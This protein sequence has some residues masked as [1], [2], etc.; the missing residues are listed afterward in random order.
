MQD[1]VTIQEK[2]GLW[3]RTNK[4]AILVELAVVFVPLY[5]CMLINDRLGS[6]VVSLG[7]STVL[8]GG[9]LL[10]IG[11]ALCLAALWVVSRMRGASWS[12]FGVTRPKSWVRT[13]LM[14]LAVLLVFIVGMVLFGALL[15]AVTDIES[16][17]LSRFAN[18][19]GNL[20]NLIINL[21]VNAWFTAGFLEE[22]LWRGYLM[23]RI[24]DLFEQKSKFAWV[25]ALIGSSIIFGLGHTYQG[26]AGVVKISIAGL[27][28]GMSFLGVKRNLW[29]LVI[30]H[31]LVDT[32][33]FVQHYFAG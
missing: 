20:P 30:A 12:D 9:P 7:G 23:N 11:L 21:V 28:L 33:T 22:F 31:A 17:D 13:V 4:L 24:T 19:Y 2:I 8:L 10:Y 5:V 29:P 15:N 6:D 27:I 32:I 14:G 18:L 16:R 1:S 25:V 3:L 26:F